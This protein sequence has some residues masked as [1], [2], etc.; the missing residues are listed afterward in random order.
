M[1]AAFFAF[2]FLVLGGFRFIAAL[3]VAL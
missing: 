1:A 2:F 3:I